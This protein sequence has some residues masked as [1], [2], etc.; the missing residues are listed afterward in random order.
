MLRWIRLLL[1]REFHLEDLFLLWD[2]LFSFSA[3]LSLIDY[4]CAA[5]LMYIRHQL[6][7]ND[8]VGCMRRLFKYPPVEDP[9]LFIEKA[10]II[11]NN[12]NKDQNHVVPPKV[13]KKQHSGGKETFHDLLKVPSHEDQTEKLK[14]EVEELKNTQLHMANRLERI[15]YSIQMEL[16][17]SN[18]VSEETIALAI[19]ELKQVKDILAGLLPVPKPTENDTIN[20]SSNNTLPGVGGLSTNKMN[21]V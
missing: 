13:T 15:I 3:N 17:R 6:L 21:K 9:H 12:R 5:M 16:V 7:G 19:A 20:L 10:L 14:E 1:G 18:G 4:I 8:K 11:R 2:A